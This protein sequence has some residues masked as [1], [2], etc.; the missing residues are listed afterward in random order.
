MEIERKRDVSNRLT[1]EDVV[2]GCYGG[3]ILEDEEGVLF[4]LTDHNE[5]VTLMRGITYDPKDMN[6]TTF[7]EVTENFIL[8]EI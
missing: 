7:V 4:I 3:S 5:L 6:N 8:K 1:G 2:K